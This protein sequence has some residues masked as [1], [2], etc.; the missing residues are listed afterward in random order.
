MTISEMSNI[1][2]LSHDTLRYY[3][4]IGLISP[5]ERTESG[6]RDYGKADMKRIDFVKCMRG[7]DMPI[8]V[9]SEYINLYQKGDATAEIRR[10]IL[11][12][13]RQAL[14]DKMDN[15]EKVIQRLDGKIETYDELMKKVK[16][17]A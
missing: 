5:V 4:R 13:Q 12:D 8:E 11:V 10:Q 3:E 1:S 9:L 6:I 14:V 17:L 7:V 16:V 2:G 15:L